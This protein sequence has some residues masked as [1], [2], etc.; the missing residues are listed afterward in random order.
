[1]MGVE[2]VVVF[3]VIVKVEVGDGFVIVRGKTDWGSDCIGDGCGHS[4]I[5]V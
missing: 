5:L 4:L 2:A 1:M 3:V